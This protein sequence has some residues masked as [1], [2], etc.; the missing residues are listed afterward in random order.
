MPTDKNTFSVY[1]HHHKKNGKMYVGITSRDVNERW[2]NGDG[3]VDCPRFYDAIREDGWDAFDH[4]VLA[5]NISEKEAMIIEN[6][7]IKRFQLQDRAYGYNIKEG[8]TSCR[9]SEETKQ[10]IGNALRGRKHSKELREKNRLAHLGKK[11]SAE[12]R[13]AISKG[14]KGRTRTEKEKTAAVLNG[15]KMSGDNHWTR[16]LGVSE[17]T[18]EAISESLREYYKTHSQHPSTTEKQVMRIEDG[19]V[20]KSIEIA[21]KEC[22]ICRSSISECASGKRK[23]AGG[24]TWKFIEKPRD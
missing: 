19:V 21:A 3:Y 10:K 2:R 16:R 22:N 4:I 13:A 15:L 14:N 12:H 6:H 18:K 1:V 11:L 17:K 7:L 20:F 8:G 23:S 24:F 9:L 5:S